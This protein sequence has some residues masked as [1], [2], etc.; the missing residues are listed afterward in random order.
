MNSEQKRLL[1]LA[2]LLDEGQSDLFKQTIGPS[3]P[4]CKYT[5]TIPKKFGWLCGKCQDV[6]RLF[7]SEDSRLAPYTSPSNEKHPSNSPSAE[8]LSQEEAD[9]AAL[10]NRDLRF[11]RR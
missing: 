3:C 8:D 10:L 4:D 5:F 7:S 6:T 11:T 9:I 1:Q 2:G